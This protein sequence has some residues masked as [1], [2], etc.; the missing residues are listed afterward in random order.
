MV[1]EDGTF[2]I[3]GLKPGTYNLLPMPSIAQLMATITVTDKDI[4][5]A[6]PSGDGVRVSGVVGLKEA[7]RAPNQKILLTGS[8][9]GRLETTTDPSGA[10]LFT[11]V[12]PG[13]HV[14]RTQDGL[15]LSSVVVA[16]RDVSGVVV[17]ALVPVTGRVLVEAGTT[18]LPP[19]LTLLATRADG[20]TTTINILGPLTVFSDGSAGSAFRVPLVEG[21]YQIQLSFIPTSFVIKSLTYG[22]TDLLKGAVY[23]GSSSPQEI[24]VIVGKN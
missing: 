6:V 8:F 24:R 1:N 20:A 23:I 9:W 14:L 18:M 17:P 11:N 15:L 21:D 19:P 4:E 12:Q 5:M 16:D 7:S 2:E 13:T 22:S 10:F 3:V